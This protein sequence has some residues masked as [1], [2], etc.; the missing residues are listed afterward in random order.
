MCFN[1]SDAHH[2]R[3]GIQIEELAVLETVQEITE[4]LYVD[5]VSPNLTSLSFLK[6][7]KVIHGRRLFK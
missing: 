4:F 5:A 6:N 3:I 2:K 7:L 1:F